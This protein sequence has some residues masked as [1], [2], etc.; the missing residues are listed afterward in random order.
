VGSNPT[1]STKETRVTLSLFC[2]PDTIESWKGGKMP[3]LI[4]KA[5]MRDNSGNL[6]TGEALLLAMLL[7]AK[8]KSK[9]GQRE[10][11]EVARMMNSRNLPR[12][13]KNV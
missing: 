8:G 4:D 3:K 10:L 5:Y 2:C 12:R 6:H 13:K 11:E 9:R 1:A 7:H